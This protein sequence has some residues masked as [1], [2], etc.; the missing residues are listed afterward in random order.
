[1]L[2]QQTI[3]DIRTLVKI[4][5]SNQN[6]DLKDK[7]FAKS[8]ET[9]YN[10]NKIKDKELIQK[11][12]LFSLISSYS[13]N[14]NIWLSKLIKHEDIQITSII[15]KD[16]KIGKRVKNN[17]INISGNISLIFTTSSAIYY[18]VLDPW[19]QYYIGKDS[20]WDFTDT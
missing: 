15:F 11:N 4:I 5:Q 7:L 6:I 16:D 8:I 12:L 14:I 19:N 9:K 20:T 10:N 13:D 3:D 17:F 18:V 1:M 2:E